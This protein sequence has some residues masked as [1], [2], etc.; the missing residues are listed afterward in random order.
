[1][2]K[3]HILDDPKYDAKGLAM[4]RVAFW[5]PAPDGYPADATRESMVESISGDELGALRDGEFIEIVRSIRV[6]RRGTVQDRAEAAR[7]KY[8]AVKLEVDRMIPPDRLR[9]EV[10]DCSE[11]GA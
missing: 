8:Q 9:G 1:M 3:A 6:N 11:G 5:V 10:I 7:K 4:V 2:K